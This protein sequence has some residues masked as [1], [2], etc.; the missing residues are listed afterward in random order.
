M[1]INIQHDS[2]TA[3]LCQILIKSRRAF[4]CY[5]LEQRLTRQQL[6]RLCTEGEGE[7]ERAS[8]R[9]TALSYGA[10]VR[11]VRLMRLGEERIP[12]TT[13]TRDDAEPDALAD[14]SAVLPQT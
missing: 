13:V 10:F 14:G 7:R 11:F 12:R 5:T 2:S 6:Q 8:C 9:G 3:L 4:L 1:F